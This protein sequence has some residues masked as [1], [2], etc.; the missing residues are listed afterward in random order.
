[1]PMASLMRGFKTT[2]TDTFVSIP[3]L[4]KFVTKQWRWGLDTNSVWFR[5]GPPDASALLVVAPEDAPDAAALLAG[6]SEDAPDVAT[7]LAGA[8][9][10]ALVAA[11]LLAGAPEDASD[12]ATLLDGVFEDAL[13]AAALLA[14]ALED[15]SDVAALLAG[16]PEDAPAVAALRA[17][18]AAALA[19]DAPVGK[20]G[21][22][23]SAFLPPMDPTL[24]LC[25]RWVVD[26]S[27]ITSALP[28]VRLKLPT[29]PRDD[30][31]HSGRS[32]QPDLGQ[33]PARERMPL[34]LAWPAGWIPQT[35]RRPDCRIRLRLA[36]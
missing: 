24:A 16:A 13:D 2:H 28:V 35:P 10:D 1:M 18:A 25:Y 30:H 36:R 34:I 15:A 22:C 23:R 4:Q 31:A 19:A 5:L 32:C 20:S 27:V 9:E 12:A 6:A 14:G 11:A 7:L 17:V 3:N 29:C 26:P 33:G 21:S 8:F